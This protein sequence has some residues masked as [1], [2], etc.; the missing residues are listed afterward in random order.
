[1]SFASISDAFSFLTE[2]G[3]VMEV[4]S[5]DDKYERLVFS[6]EEIRIVIEHEIIHYAFFLSIYLGDKKVDVNKLFENHN[7]PYRCKYEY[8]DKS[9]LEKGIAYMKEAMKRLVKEIYPEDISGFKAVLSEALL[10]ESTETMEERYLLAADQ[11][12]LAGDYKQAVHF[13]EQAG[14]IL[15]DLQKRRYIRAKEMVNAPTT[16]DEDR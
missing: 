7:L 13:Y 2:S 3:Y 14:P 5:S 6:R 10:P 16:I 12:Y 1:M 4:E 11:R 9:R 15:N 8:P